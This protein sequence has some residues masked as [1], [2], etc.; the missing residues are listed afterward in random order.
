MGVVSTTAADPGRI[1]RAVWAQGRFVRDYAHRSL[2]PVEVLALVRYR[3]DFA[4]RALELG[5]GAGRIAGYL[6]DLSEQAFGIDISPRMIEECRRRYPG[7]TFIEGDIRDLS[8][9]ED[10]SL[11]AVIAGCNVLDI[12]G[13]EERRGTLREVRRVLRPGGLYLMSSHNRDYLPSV[14]RPTQLR[15]N[16]PLRFAADA[17]RAPRRLLRHR[18]LVGLEQQHPDY[19]IVSDG[20]HGYSL[21]HYFITPASQFRQ[22][23]QEGFEPLHCVDLDGREIAL[24]EP[25]TDRVELHYLARRT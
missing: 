19:A 15:T 1:N 24:G 13:D 2:R 9:F 4:G 23:E 20:A 21:V 22:L 8:Y 14:R 6:V 18:R 7:G 17:V 25:A 12:F 5:C 11:D 10:G 3:E 16:D